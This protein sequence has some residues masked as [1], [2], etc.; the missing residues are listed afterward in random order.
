VASIHKKTGASGVESPFWQAKF[1]GLEGRPVWLTTK[2]K[3]YRKAMAVAERWEKAAQLASDWELWNKQQKILDD[4][5]ELT[6]SLA[7]KAITKRL[8][9]GLLSDTIG[10]E[11]KGE[12]FEKFCSE[13]LAGKKDSRATAESTLTRY[14]GIVDGFLSRLP[15]KRRQASVGSITAIE[16]QRFRNSEIQAGKTAATANFGVKVLRALF[17]TAPA[18]EH[19]SK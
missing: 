6:K 17:N 1:R 18:S 9:D 10:E 3:D 14:K 11:L 5:W 15:E 7:T 16:I 19:H 4:V 12:N 8:L 2:Q 13:W